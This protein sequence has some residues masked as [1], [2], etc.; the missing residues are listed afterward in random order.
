M[1]GHVKILP[2]HIAFSPAKKNDDGGEARYGAAMTPATHILPTWHMASQLAMLRLP[3]LAEELRRRFGATA[4]CGCELEWYI[5]PADREEQI[6]ALYAAVSQKAAEAGLRI[7]PIKREEGKGQYE[8]GFDVTNQPAQLAQAIHD[9]RALLMAEAAHRGLEV[10]WDAKPHA[11]DYG[12]ALQLHVHLVDVAGARL[13]IKRDAELSDALAACLGGLLDVTPEAV[14]IAAPQEE[15]YA[16]FVPK[17]DAPVTVCWGGN[18]RSTTIRLPLKTGAKCHIEYRLAGADADA[19]SMLAVLLA[20]VLHGLEKQPHPGAQIHGVA[21]DGQYGLPALPDTRTK[22]HALF[23][24]GKI[25]RRWLGKDW[26]AAVEQAVA[27]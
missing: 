1:H 25:L 24:Q 23:A 19:A 15:S 10:L 13:F 9:F 11:D 12:S 17:C 20:G 27:S 22:A 14:L 6:T 2:Q 18:N 3:E 26:V 21:S 8:V 5:A 16:R 7:T 4:Y